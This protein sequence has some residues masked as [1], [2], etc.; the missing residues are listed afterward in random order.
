MVKNKVL[1]QTIVSLFLEKH[2]QAPAHL[3][4]AATIGQ[5]NGSIEVLLI[6]PIL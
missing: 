3:H 6:E 1:I 4:M 2:E 5:G